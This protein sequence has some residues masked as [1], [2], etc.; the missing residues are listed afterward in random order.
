MEPNVKR[1]YV[2]FPKKLEQL[3]TKIPSTIFKWTEFLL[4]IVNLVKYNRYMGKVEN[5]GHKDLYFLIHPKIQISQRQFKYTSKP[6][7]SIPKGTEINHSFL[8][9]RPCSLIC[10]HLRTLQ[11][12]MIGSSSSKAFRFGQFKPLEGSCH[13]R[14]RYSELTQ[15][16]GGGVSWPVGTPFSSCWSISFTQICITLGLSS[17][18]SMSVIPICPQSLGPGE[19]FSF[20]FLL[21]SFRIL[22]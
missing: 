9:L 19:P 16:C 17:P 15:G 11:A 7:P 10:P 13:Q 8:N 22:V 18:F 5:N 6:Q 12:W 3:G 14:V 4:D 21:F 2:H 1:E 20:I